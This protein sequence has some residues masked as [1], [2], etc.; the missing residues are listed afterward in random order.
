MKILELWNWWCLCFAFLI[1]VISCHLNISQQHCLSSKFCSCS[2][3]RPNK[4]MLRPEQRAPHLF[5]KTSFPS[6]NPD[7]PMVQSTKHP[8]VKLL[9]CQDSEPKKRFHQ[10]VLAPEPNKRFENISNCLKR[11]FQNFPP[12][13][14][15]HTKGG[16]KETP[17]FKSDIP[18]P[19]DF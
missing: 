15:T 1:I 19:G 3:A 12:I 6:S 9:R 8:R 2:K 16:L 5:Q 11:I 13:K 14:C 18:K 17:V 4:L 7:L 10:A